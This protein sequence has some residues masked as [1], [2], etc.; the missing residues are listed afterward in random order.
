MSMSLLEYSE[1]LRSLTEKN[2]QQVTIHKV[3]KPKRKQLIRK[4]LTKK[5]P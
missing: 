5:K 4:Q 3:R 1:Y 2:T